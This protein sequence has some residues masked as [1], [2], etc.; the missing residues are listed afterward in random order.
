MRIAGTE[1]DENVENRP[2]NKVSSRSNGVRQSALLGKPRRSK[3]ERLE[4]SGRIR[5]R[6]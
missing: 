5:R 3:E 4:P 2:K 1:F 6:S